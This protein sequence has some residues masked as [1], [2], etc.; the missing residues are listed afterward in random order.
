LNSP[1]AGA[2]NRDENQATGGPSSAELAELMERL[3]TPVAMRDVDFRVVYQNAAHRR[4]FG[5]ARGQACYAVYRGATA[6]CPDCRGDVAADASA[7]P[8]RCFPLGD[9]RAGHEVRLEAPGA[10][11]MTGLLGRFFE[12]SGAAV[13]LEHL[14]GTIL[15]MN[16][17]AER[18]YGYDRGEWLGR[19]VLDLIPEEAQALFPI[20]ARQLQ[21]RGAFSVETAQRR[22]DGSLFR[23]QVEGFRLEGPE[24]LVLV[25]VR[26]VTVASEERTALEV[27]SREFDQLLDSVAHDLRS[28]LV[29]IK[30]YAN[31]IDRALP[32]GDEGVREHLGRVL[33]QTERME[34]LLEDL[35]QLSRIGRAEELSLDLDVGSSARAA[36]QDL[37]EAARTSGATLV[38]AGPLPEVRMAPVRLTQVFANLFSNAIR[39]GRDGVAPRIELSALASGLGRKA[40]AGTVC[41]RGRGN[42]VGVDPEEREKIFELFRQGSRAHRDGSGLGLAIVRRIVESYG[43][44]IWVGAEEGPGTSFYLLLPGTEKK[45]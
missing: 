21:E 6:P 16:R 36:W 14:D 34:S 30:G 23:A 27:R 43:G 11:E 31:M 33:R 37:A 4:L 13:F 25:T 20:V 7:G 26:D 28:P 17:A 10:E 19:S 2:P 24:P 12:S 9:G 35:L 1:C 18:L 44:R 40:E 3:S 41:L 15:A 45:R 22:A 8:G 29:G 5:E 32:A 38:L 42:G 39:Y